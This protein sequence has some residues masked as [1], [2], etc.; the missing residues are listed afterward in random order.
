M[1]K[2][3]AVDTETTGLFKDDGAEVKVISLCD[4]K[5]PRAYILDEMTDRQ[6][7]KLYD[8]LEKRQLIFHNAKF[9]LHMLDSGS[10]GRDLQD[11]FYWDTMLAIRIL[12]PLKPAALKWYCRGLWGVDAVQAADDLDQFL[13]DNKLKKDKLWTA[14]R[15]ILI[16]YAAADADLTWRLY[17][18]QL[19]QL[20]ECSN[21]IEVSRILNREFS[22]CKTLYR[23]E[24]RGVGWDVTGA[25]LAAEKLEKRNE[26]IAAKLPFRP[27]PPQAGR[28]FYEEQGYIPTE[29]TPKGKPSIGK[30]A[31][32]SLIEQGA[33]WAKE[34][35]LYERSK[36]WASMWYRGW[37]E[38]AGSD[39]R[40]R[41]SFRQLGAVSMRF[42][43]ERIQLQAIP[44]DYQM[45]KDLPKNVPT[46]RMLFRAADGMQ[47]W[48]IDVS[49]AEVRIATAIAKCVKMR[50]I[51]EAGEDVHDAT[52]REIFDLTPEDDEWPRHRNIAKRLNF[53]M[54]YG[55]GVRGLQE[56]VRIHAGVEISENQARTYLD[57]HRDTFPEFVRA[58]QLA[59]IR[60]ERRGH[61][62]LCSGMRRWFAPGEELHK[63]FNQVIQG[64]VAEAM[65][66]W[67]MLVES[68]YP[69]SLLLQIHDSLVLELPEDEA[70]GSAWHIRD[71]GTKVFEHYFKIPFIAEAKQW[72]K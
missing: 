47:L 66:D 27:T 62:R 41:T 4:E 69:D 7:D 52:C 61:V 2:A 49:Q 9:D 25:M 13:L 64:G 38:K 14:P 58:A 20:D 28:F 57:A 51:I 30:A 42:S 21:D 59:E 50:E 16:E 5:G 40:L 3:V 53:A 37:T 70:E 35:D 71:M 11:N 45:G 39:G 60:A 23:M 24:K 18:H 17:H 56:Q 33:E 6:I 43:V 48:E 8:W 19:Q 72:L 65:K 63:A 68:S 22:V 1:D 55:A 34:Y 54:V 29:M 36:R 31:R 15:E 10:H 67:M 46:P 26:K 44:H 12:D 32:R